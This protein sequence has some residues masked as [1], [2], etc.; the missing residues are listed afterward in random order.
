MRDVRHAL[1]VQTFP[2][3]EAPRPTVKISGLRSTAPSAATSGSSGDAC[4]RSGSLSESETALDLRCRSWRMTSRGHRHHGSQEEKARISLVSEAAY[5][6]RKSEALCAAGAG[7]REPA[8][9]LGGQTGS[10]RGW[11]QLPRV[12][13]RAR[14]VTTR[15]RRVG[16]LQTIE[17]GAI[18]LEAGGTEGVAGLSLQLEACGEVR[19]RAF[20]RAPYHV[21][22]P[23]AP[24]RP[25]TPPVSFRP[26]CAQATLAFFEVNAF[27]AFRS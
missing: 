2:T 26:F 9:C 15:G 6:P 3:C 12:G 13:E 17:S 10:A 20:G 1:E 4:A 19:R 24:A 16:R 25:L 23:P 14:W 18:I 11:E 21:S 8:I 27:V 5:G 22:T 7:T